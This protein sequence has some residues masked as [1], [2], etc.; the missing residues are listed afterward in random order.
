MYECI[1]KKCTHK[2][3]YPLTIRDY[4]GISCLILTSAL[5]SAAGIGGGSLLYPI[6]L[7]ILKFQTHE[8]VPLSKLTIFSCCLITFLIS[9]NAKH[10]NR[11]AIAIDYNIIG[12]TVP[13]ILF[14]TTLGVVIHKIL[15]FS[16][17][18][19]S[20]IIVLLYSTFKTFYS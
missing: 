10:P 16:I 12:I 7:V 17:I 20:L 14:G 9:L 4:I 5:S 1:N 19:I 15:P 18:L 8:A 11:D 2:G 3:I 13:M 6:Y